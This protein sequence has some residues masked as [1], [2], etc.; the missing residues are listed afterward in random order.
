MIWLGIAS[1]VKVNNTCSWFPCISSVVSL[2][3]YMSY[4]PLLHAVVRR[5]TLAAVKKQPL[6]LQ[7]M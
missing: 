3:E 6:R 4:T 2:G 7:H 5:R 1:V